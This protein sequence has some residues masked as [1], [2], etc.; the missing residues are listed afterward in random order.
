MICPGNV[1]ITCWISANKLFKRWKLDKISRTFQGNTGINTEQTITLNKITQQAAMLSIY[2]MLYIFCILL[3]FHNYSRIIGRK[4]KDDGISLTPHHY[5]LPL[6]R[7]L[8][9]AERLLHRAH[10]C[11]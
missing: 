2:P 7:H 11:A 10:L 4:G 8:S 1:R 3:F 5:F 6:H 9:L